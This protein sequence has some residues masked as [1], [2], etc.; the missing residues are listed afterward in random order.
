MTI[1]CS[2]SMLLRAGKHGGV[3][4]A[5]GKGLAPE[6]YRLLFQNRKPMAQLPLEVLQHGYSLGQA[7]VAP[8]DETVHLALGIAQ[9][10]DEALGVDVTLRFQDHV[11]HQQD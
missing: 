7:R 3:S 8:P 10:T 2:R 1:S 4:L 6:R 5:A 9:E 11:K